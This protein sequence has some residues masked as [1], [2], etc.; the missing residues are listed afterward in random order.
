[1]GKRFKESKESHVEITAWNKWI[2]FYYTV[3]GKNFNIALQ[4]LWGIFFSIAPAI[5][6]KAMEK[7]SLEELLH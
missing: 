1:M 4:S 2:D 3:R 6:F 5:S 7:F